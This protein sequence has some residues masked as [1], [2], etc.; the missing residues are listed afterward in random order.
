[1]N[2][3]NSY[4][5]Y[6]YS[7]TNKEIEKKY[8]LLGEGIS[9]KVYDLKNGL[10]LKLAKGQEGYYQNSVEY[11]VFSNAHHKYL[12]YLCPIL[13]FTPRL[14]I[15]KK[16]CPLTKTVKY[17]Y[18]DI[19]KIRSE[20]SSLYDLKT[21]TRDFMLFYEDIISTS[22]WGELNHKNV[23]IDY[24]CTSEHGDVYYNRLFSF[25]YTFNTG[26]AFRKL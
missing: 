6:L 1:M 15:M 4:Y 21:L 19:R 14:V 3:S 20:K 18:I 5:S 24:G 25:Y 16:A 9:R 10:V 23:L 11:Y 2:N 26:T 22:S 12:K 17:K 13:C 8:K 7:L